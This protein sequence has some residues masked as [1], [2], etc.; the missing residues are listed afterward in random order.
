MLTISPLSQTSL[1]LSVKIGSDNVVVRSIRGVVSC[2]RRTTEVWRAAVNVPAG[3]GRIVISYEMKKTW[4]H[5]ISF[6]QA[7]KNFRQ[8][9][10]GFRIS[11]VPLNFSTMVFFSASTF[12]FPDQNFRQEEDF[13]GIF[14][15]PKTSVGH[16]PTSPVPP[17]IS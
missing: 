17:T 8:G 12:A 9:L 5:L 10:R 6:L 11:A 16:L 13:R 15:Q 7:D 4:S 2:E 14:R 3:Y 1:A